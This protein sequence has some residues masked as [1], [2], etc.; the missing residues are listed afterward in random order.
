MWAAQADVSTRPSDTHTLIHIILTLF[1]TQSIYSWNTYVAEL[2]LKFS[3]GWKNLN[4]FKNGLNDK[5]INVLTPHRN[6]KSSISDAPTLK[7]PKD[8]FNND[9]T[10]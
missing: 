1:H 4:W 9:A 2:Q 7:A 8:G 3:F 10:E 6:M 5:D